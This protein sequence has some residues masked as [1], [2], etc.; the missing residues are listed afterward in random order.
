MHIAAELARLGPAVTTA[1]TPGRSPSGPV[2]TTPSSP[3][4][5]PSGP[6]ATTPSSPGRSPSG[7]VATTAYSPGRSAPSS[8]VGP[9]QP[10]GVPSPS[11]YGAANAVPST[12]NNVPSATPA[13]GLR[14]PPPQQGYP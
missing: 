9:E 2:A 13:A 8:P 7:P 6:V 11:S 5:N 12:F 1:R 14:P 10:Y 4:R 3:G